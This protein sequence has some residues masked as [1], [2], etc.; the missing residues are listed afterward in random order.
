MRLPDGR[1]AVVKLEYPLSITTASALMKGIAETLEGLGWTDV[2]LL[3]DGT[4]RIAGTPP[5][6]GG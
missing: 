3:L 4:D 6:R 5:P 1:E 2:V